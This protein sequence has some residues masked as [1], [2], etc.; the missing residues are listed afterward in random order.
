[1]DPDPQHRDRDAHLG[2]RL[3]EPGPGNHLLRGDK[4]HVGQ[5][6]DGVDK[7]EEALLAVGPVEEP[8]RVEEEGEGGLGLGVVLQEVLHHK[9]SSWSSVH[10]V[11][12]T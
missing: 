7:L 3:R 6:Q 11:G 8:G 9:W 12:I 2:Q 1:M 5:G 10:T 4:V